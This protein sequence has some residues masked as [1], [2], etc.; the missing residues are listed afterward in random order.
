[1]G[2][3]LHL[4]P[5][6]RVNGL[7]CR[8]IVNHM[9]VSPG[10]NGGVVGRLGPAFNLDTVHPGFHQIL[11][12]VDGAHIPGVENVGALFVLVHR[13]ILP[14]PLFLHEGVLV[15][16]GL[17]TGTPVGIPPGH[18]V[19]QKAPAGIADAHGAVAEGFDFQ[20]LGGFLPD[21]ADFLQA[22][23]S[24]QHHPG[25]SQVIPGSGTFVVCHGL[26]GGDMPLAFGG[27][28]PRQGKGSQVCHNQGVHPGVLELL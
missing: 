8:H 14:W 24:G 2:H 13:E 23:L 1:M 25:G 10:D 15:P 26:L 5:P 27:V 4:V 3:M 22:Q 21:G 6:H 9:A 19:A 20:L 18:V 11:Q 12:V 16:A 7:P 17:G 28:L